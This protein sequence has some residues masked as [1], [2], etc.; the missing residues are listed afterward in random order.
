MVITVFIVFWPP[1]FLGS[2][3]LLFCVAKNRMGAVLRMT[4]CLPNMPSP[5]PYYLHLWLCCKGKWGFKPLS[6]FPRNFGCSHDFKTKKLMIIDVSTIFRQEWWSTNA[7]YVLSHTFKRPRTFI[8]HPLSWSQAFLYLFRQEGTGEMA[9]L[10]GIVQHEGDRNRGI[11]SAEGAA[12]DIPVAFLLD[13]YWIVVL[14][15]SFNVILFFGVIING[16]FMGLMRY[17][18]TMVVFLAGRVGQNRLLMGFKIGLNHLF[19]EYLWD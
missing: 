10:T 3:L 2:P 19:M 18:W 6:V 4:G 13:S 17:S 7:L 5:A 1:L 9:V 14:L 11:T 8:L 12:P 16:S 15:C